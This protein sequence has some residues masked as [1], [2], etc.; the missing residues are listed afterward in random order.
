MNSSD[1]EESNDE[2]TSKQ[3][4]PPKLKKTQLADLRREA[5]QVLK[6]YEGDYKNDLAIHLYS[7]H[8]MHQMDPGFPKRIWTSWPLPPED[9]PDP[10]STS[11]Y[12]DDDPDFVKEPGIS[13]LG[14]NEDDDDDDQIQGILDYES[15]QQ[16]PSIRSDP[17]EDLKIELDALFKRKIYAGIQKLAISNKDYHLQPSLDYPQF[18]D[19]IE[20]KIKEK[21]DQLMN[22]FPKPAKFPRHHRGFFNW[23]DLLLRSNI[24]D[25]DFINKTEDIFIQVPKRTLKEFEESN[26]VHDS[27]DIDDEEDNEDDQAN[28]TNE[29]IRTKEP[30]H[31]SAPK[32]KKQLKEKDITQEKTLKLRSEITQLLYENMKKKLQRDQPQKSDYENLQIKSYSL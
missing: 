2:E 14:M 10:N 30:Q 27:E 5:K 22:K 24:D 31:D 28:V 19:L 29:S 13:T 8:L 20:E 26:E 16:D 3:I 15:E 7:T 6:H 12:C 17:D 4:H 18:P 25:L 1:H 23:R 11:T 21:I 9:V 32:P